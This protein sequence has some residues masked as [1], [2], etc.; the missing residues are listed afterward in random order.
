MPYN[1]CTVDL[2]SDMKQ[3]MAPFFANYFKKV[4]PSKD[5]NE[6]LKQTGEAATLTKGE[7]RMIIDHLD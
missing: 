2:Y 5:V 4:H 3:Y 1:I 6:L 7:V